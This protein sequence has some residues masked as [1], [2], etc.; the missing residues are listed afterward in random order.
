MARIFKTLAL[1]GGQA[2]AR[3][4]GLFRGAGRSATDRPTLEGPESGFVDVFER[5]VF[6]GGE[7]PAGFEFGGEGKLAVG[8]SRELAVD[9]AE[10]GL[11]GV[12]P[13]VEL[14]ATGLP[15]ADAE[16]AGFAEDDF[17]EFCD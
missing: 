17:F 2:R 15:A 4:C 7:A 1:K 9:G 3:G 12:G 13:A 6:F 10:G 5:E 11:D 14:V 8:E 16:G